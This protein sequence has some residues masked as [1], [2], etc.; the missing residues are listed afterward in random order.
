MKPAGVV[1]C[2]GAS[3]RMGQDKALLHVNGQ[4]FLQ[5]CLDDMM[6]HCHSLY[7]LAAPEQRIT[8]DAGVRIVHD[9]AAFVGPASALVH[10]A[11]HSSDDWLLVRAVDMP[12]ARTADF[13][14]CVDDSVASCAD[15]VMARIDGRD[16]PLLAL[17]RR[18][19]LAAVNVAFP[20]S[21]FALLDSLKTSHIPLSGSRWR[22]FNHPEELREINK[23]K[24][25]A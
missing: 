6:P 12:F 19:A 7:V 2:G 16:Q 10:F 21:M 25:V 17:Y 5:L 20:C 22:N 1:L 23:E 18:R 11:R 3:R 9:T 24:G 14:A 8:A 13:M 15:V 4:S